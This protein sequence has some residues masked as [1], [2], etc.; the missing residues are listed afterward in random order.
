MNDKKLA[1]RRLVKKKSSASTSRMYEA[2]QVLYAVFFVPLFTITALGPQS[3]I[4]EFIVPTRNTA[5]EMECLGRCD[6]AHVIMPAVYVLRQTGSH[7]V[8]QIKKNLWSFMRLVI[9]THIVMMVK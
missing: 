9:I 2:V 8:E 4:V 5:I 1:L 7:T 3:F 6:H